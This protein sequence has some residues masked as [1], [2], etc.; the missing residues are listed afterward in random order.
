MA[1]PPLRTVPKP[2]EGITIRWN[3]PQQRYDILSGYHMDTE[4]NV[5]IIG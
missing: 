5:R 3:H 1:T 4:C 2:G